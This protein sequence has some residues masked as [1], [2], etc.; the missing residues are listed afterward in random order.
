MSK[1]SN[2]A[3]SAVIVIILSL[4][5]A[6]G[7]FLG[8]T[9]QPGEAKGPDVIEQAWNIIDSNYVD[10]DELDSA[11]MTR[12]AIDGIIGTLDD[13][14]TILFTSDEYRQFSESLHGEYA[15]IGAFVTLRDGKITIVAPIP[16][17][18]AEKAGIK[19][20]DIVL[21]INGE[22]TAGLELEIAVSKIKGPEGTKVKLLILRAGEAEPLE[23]EIT[24][25]IIELPSVSYKMQ[26][27]IACITII[28]FT[29]RTDYELISALEKS[30]EDNAKGIVLDLRNNGGGLLD[31]AVAVASHFL[32]S[33]TVATTKDG[34]GNI[35]EYKVDT[36]ALR[37]D[38]PMVVLVNEY[39]ASAS[40][41]VAGALQDYGRATISGN[42]TYGKGSA[43][44]AFGLI[45]GSALNVTIARWYTPDGRLIE[46]RGITPDIKLE[47]TWE[48]ELQWAIDYLNGK[49]AA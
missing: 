28:Q 34:K 6:G 3:I 45:D 13:P 27:G 20:G 14:Y 12:S 18:P 19:A 30:I 25:A 5:F 17:S 42:T 10:R 4:A 39:T 9:Y 46:G 2:I 15:G 43:T 26:Q 40:E 31:I 41:I 7:F 29:D 35:T 36:G 16:D 1:L 44:V 49:S 38:L 32:D 11:K 33:G 22:P 23:I 37:T 8:Q 21:E 47:L 48:A 24:R